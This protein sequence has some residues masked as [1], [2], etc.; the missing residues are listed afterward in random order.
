M[1]WHVQYR[2]SVGDHLEMLSTPERAIEVACVL[3]A[4]GHDVYGIGIGTPHSESI[5]REQIGRIYA[6]W[7]RG[8]PPVMRR[9][10]D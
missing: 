10:A 1:D 3:I 6:M 4:Q 5:N 8:R 9:P 7:A 2:D